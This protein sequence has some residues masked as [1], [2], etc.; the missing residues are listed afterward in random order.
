VNVYVESNF[1]LQLALLQESHSSCEAI[2]QLCEGDESRL[3]IPAFSLVE[4]S[5][6]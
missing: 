2:L 1:V 6:V 3:V 5:T 4:P